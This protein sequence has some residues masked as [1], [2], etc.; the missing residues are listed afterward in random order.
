MKQ[1]SLIVIALALILV[2][3]SESNKSASFELK[4]K[5]NGSKGEWLYFEKLSGQKP[6][7]L[8]SVILNENGE[9]EFSTYT[10]K[11]G[12]YRIKLNNQNFAMLVLDSSDKVMLTG[13]ASDLSNNY[14]VEGSV[15]TKLFLEY[16]QISKDRD[17]RLDS[18]NKMFQSTMEQNKMDSK[19]MDSI[20]ALFEAPYNAIVNQANALIV[21]KVKNNTDK[22]SSMVAIQ[23]LEPDKYADLYQELDK[24]LSKRFP[25]DRSVMMFHDVVG[26]MMATNMGQ[27]APEIVLPNPEGKE[28]ALSSLRGKVVLLD[29]W[30][31]WCGPCRKEMPNVVNAY[32]KYKSKGFE[33]YGVSLDQDRDRWIEAIAKDGM[34]W[35]QVSDLKYWESNAARLYNVQSIPYTLLL[36]KEGKII[37]KNLRGEALDKRLAELLN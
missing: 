30:A 20:S 7:L 34:T 36:D 23:S 25:S 10:P 33:I 27:V 21:E 12:F 28:I 32:A 16:N 5:L 1:V 19:R 4:G 17:L 31:S 14:K 37:D 8:D 24:G 22:Y 13:E 9:F 3:C 11:I 6:V 29:F 18:L 35:P 26:K 15:E 2:S